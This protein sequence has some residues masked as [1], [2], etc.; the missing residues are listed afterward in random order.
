MLHYHRERSM[1]AILSFV[2]G[3]LLFVGLPVLGWGLGDVSGFFSDPARMLYV[4][5]AVGVSLWVV[6]AIPNAGR[7]QGAGQ[8]LVRRQHVVVVLLQ[9]LS[10]ALV[11]VSPYCDRRGLAVL[12]DNEP[13]RLV[14]VV[15]YAF[16]F[17]LSALAVAALGRQ[18]S[19][20]VTIQENHRLI[21]TGPY[22]LL[23]HPRYAG[24]VAFF[25]GIGF[26]FRSGVSLLLAA[27][28]A[29]VL[30]WRI[31]DEERLMDNEFGL[32]WQRYASKTW[33]LVPYVY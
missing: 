26:V 20:E 33:R 24:I 32:E 16:G 30:L 21:T 9:V 17:V 15:A 2:F 3:V 13:L 27:C 8:K 10:I 4:V 11:L 14:G 23:R 1:R 5:T 19:I 29:A 6:I 12:G 7:S 28:V 31:H 22:R 18:F 25:F